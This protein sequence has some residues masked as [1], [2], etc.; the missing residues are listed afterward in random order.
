MN[1]NLRRAVYLSLALLV[2][3][4]AIALF[5]K[6]LSIAFKLALVGMAIVLGLFMLVRSRFRR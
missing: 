3:A 4:L 5:A 1:G 2:A 6:A